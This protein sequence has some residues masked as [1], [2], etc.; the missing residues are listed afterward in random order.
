[1]QSQLKELLDN[2]DNIVYNISKIKK[3]LKEMQS[4]TIN[5]YEN[6]KL[7]D[8]V[9]FYMDGDILML[10]KEYYGDDGFNINQEKNKEQM[11]FIIM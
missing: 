6:E 7:N 11:P 2:K 1:M 8:F 4:Y 3:L 10:K 9:D 5:V